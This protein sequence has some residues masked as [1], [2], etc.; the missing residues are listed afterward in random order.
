MIGYS[1]P[2]SLKPLIAEAAEKLDISMS[3]FVEISIKE[4]I[5]AIQ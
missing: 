2:I 4:K 1:L 5:Q 3:E